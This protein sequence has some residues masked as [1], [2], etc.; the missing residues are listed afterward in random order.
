MQIVPLGLDSLTTTQST[1]SS[2]GQSDQFATFLSGMQQSMN[3]GTPTQTQGSAPPSGSQSA[4]LD[5]HGQGAKT[6]EPN[7]PVKQPDPSSDHTSTKDSKGQDTSPDAT[8]A[9]ATLAAQINAAST[10]LQKASDSVPSTPKDPTAATVAVATTAS[11][12]ATATQVQAEQM[13]AAQ[14]LGTAPTS[15]PT[16]GVPI[17]VNALKAAGSTTTG[18]SSKLSGAVAQLP[19]DSDS[20]PTQSSGGWMYGKTSNG[21]GGNTAVSTYVNGQGLTSS[22]VVSGK[23]ATFDLPAS[24]TASSGKFSSPVPA[25]LNQS[26]GDASVVGAA[27][28]TAN[29]NVTVDTS[30]VMSAPAVAT[31][32]AQATSATTPTDSQPTVSAPQDVPVSVTSVTQSVAQLS[33]ARATQ[34]DSK[35]A[36]TQSV[37]PSQVVDPTTAVTP[38]PVENQPAQ[39]PVAQIP[40]AQ[41]NTD[42]V[43]QKVDTQTQATPSTA[44]TSPTQ[45]SQPQS[46]VAEPSESA[47]LKTNQ[48]AAHPKDATSA[49]TP[50]TD[51]PTS[52]VDSPAPTTTTATLPRA[53]GVVTSQD[54]GQTS[55]QNSTPVAST[56][57]PVQPTVTSSTDQVTTVAAMSGQG[58]SSTGVNQLNQGGNNRA[59][60]VS[61]DVTTTTTS[62]SA[63]NAV[64]NAVATAHSKSNADADSGSTGGHSR[65][66]TSAKG[67]GSATSSSTATPTDTQ[68][69]STSTSSTTGVTNVDASKAHSVD[70]VMLVR[71]V[72]DKMELLAATHPKDGVVIHLEPANLGSLTVTLKQTA[73]GVDAQMSASNEHVRKA[74]QE[75]RTDLTT[76]MQQRGIEMK[77]IS[78]STST[79]TGNGSGNGSS[80]FGTDSQTNQ[81]ARN[82]SQQSQNSYASTRDRL[83]SSDGTTTEENR[84]VQVRSSGLDVWI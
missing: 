73:A 26:A 36:D 12:S 11:A 10:S 67:D 74:L 16:V 69:T 38:Q 66:E 56:P 46:A 82:Q 31:A 63:A 41:F 39:I 13:L 20:T 40:T 50:Q 25:Y 62:E 68:T 27:K 44:S 83:T 79:A 65:D 70:R 28:S 30:A 6:A 4:G 76:A 81:Q 51:R 15:A 47:Q 5:T 77:S 57:T 33:V 59:T 9:A 55:A 34:L 35:R 8:S 14:L 75:S 23:A 52:I 2:T 78:V 64:V 48:D 32:N 37:A 53:T 18:Q 84:R 21:A 60:A 43:A 54:A 72:A 1:G 22:D 24:L 3:T 80:S 17:D 61:D 58:G 29:S 42:V 19:T 49:A 45:V 71:Q 7:A